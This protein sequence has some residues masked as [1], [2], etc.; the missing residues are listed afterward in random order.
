VSP[1]TTV[2]VWVGTGVGAGVGATVGATVG[3]G[4]GGGVRAQQ[5][6]AIAASKGEVKHEPLRNT[7]KKVGRNDPCPC[8]SGKKYKACCLRS[9]G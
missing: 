5:E 2:Y 9:G 8:G 4:V 6:A 7:G 3:A 1:W